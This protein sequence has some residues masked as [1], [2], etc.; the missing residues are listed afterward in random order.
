MPGQFGHI[1]LLT[2]VFQMAGRTNDRPFRLYW[3]N[4]VL[5]AEVAW[6]QVGGEWRLVVSFVPRRGGYGFVDA[7]ENSPPLDPAFDK[8]RLYPVADFG[9]MMERAGLTPDKR[10]A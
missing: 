9:G 8:Y 3:G 4:V 2:L 5:C 7:G 6:Y 1:S 10:I